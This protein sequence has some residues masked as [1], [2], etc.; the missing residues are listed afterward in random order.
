[1]ASAAEKKHQK[2]KELIRHHDHLYY[3]LDRPELT[4]F[5]YDQLL[6]ELFALEAVHPELSLSD[7]P[8]Q[9]VGG[10]ALDVFKK[11]P[12][13]VQMLSLANS[14]SPEDLFE[15]DARVKKVLGSENDLLDSNNRDASSASV[16]KSA[17]N[18]CSLSVINACPFSCT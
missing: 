2:L 7:S 15:F 1:M 14:Y 8:S 3:V 9:R 18:D 11:V 16:E 13:R 6:A 12:H 17:V 10:A 4:D 5:Q